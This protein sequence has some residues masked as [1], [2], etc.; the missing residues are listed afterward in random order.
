MKNNLKKQLWISFSLV[1]ATLII[2]SVALYYIAGDIAVKADKIVSDRTLI[3]QQTGAI[4]V[5]TNLKAQ[6]PQAM[7]YEAAMENLLPTQD[8]LIGFGDWLNGIAATNQVSANFSFQEN[9]TLATAN[10]P[11]DT[12]VSLSVSGPISNIENFLEDVESSSPGF[13]VSI[14]SFDLSQSNGSY[15]LTAQGDTYSR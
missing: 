8:G 14:D 15:Q 7:S 5:L 9:A 1:L 10:T 12:G 11:G 4:A 6:E 13:L 3:D 2:A